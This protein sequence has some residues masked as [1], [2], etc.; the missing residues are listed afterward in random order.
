MYIS[1]LCDSCA[2]NFRNSRN[3]GAFTYDVRCLGRYSEVPNRSVAFFLF[4]IGIFPTYIALLGTILLFIFGKKSQLY[5]FLRNEYRKIP[6]YAPIKTRACI[7]NLD[8]RV[9]FFWRGAGGD[10]IGLNY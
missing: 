3:C 1:F 7:R 2:Q 4:F 8:L 9:H 6:T 5:C 10:Q